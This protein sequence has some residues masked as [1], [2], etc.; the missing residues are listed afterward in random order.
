MD[1]E[2]ID[3]IGKGSYGVIYKVK[4]RSQIQVLKEISL[5]NLSLKQQN[6][7]YREAQIMH[8][9][10]HP[11]IVSYYNS[12]LRKDKLNIFMEFCE[13]DLYNYICRNP[14]PT[15]NQVWQWTIQLLEGVE[16]LHSQKIMHRDI[17][18]NNILMK[19]N[20][21][22]ISDLGVSKSL[23]STQQLQTT[24][25]G[26]PLYLAPELIRNR[27]YDSKIDIWA[28]GCVIYFICQG[29][30]PFGGSNIISLG[31]NIVNKSPKPINCKYSRKLQSL[32]FKLLNKVPEFR[33]TATQ[34]LQQ[35]REDNDV[36]MKPQFQKIFSVHSQQDI[37]RG[38]DLKEQNKTVQ[39]IQS[40]RLERII[41]QQK[42]AQLRL[43]EADKF[44]K[45]VLLNRI[46][47]HQSEHYVQ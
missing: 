14:S 37:T 23:I 27:P 43:C 33:P 8:T 26:T 32:I 41:Q 16:Y 28:L 3:Q 13:D 10:N 17:K 24:K 22:K 11:N 6:E 18:P 4:I 36:K 34:A 40:R 46:I 5:K 38:D 47:K 25:V 9:L 42:D 19:S 39:M 20:V 1:Y 44:S 21:L 2:I 7:A 30:P 15:E 45:I 31:Y 29:D 35:I 12:Q